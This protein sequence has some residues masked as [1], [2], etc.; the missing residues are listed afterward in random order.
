VGARLGEVI[1]AIERNATVD[2]VVANY[3]ARNAL[4]FG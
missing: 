1:A 2:A 4:R 3:A